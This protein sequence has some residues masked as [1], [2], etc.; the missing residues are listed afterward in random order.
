MDVKETNELGTMALLRVE[1]DGD[2][3]TMIFKVAV[4]TL[5]TAE[6]IYGSATM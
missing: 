3:L 1:G 4:V 6:I 5:M 2:I